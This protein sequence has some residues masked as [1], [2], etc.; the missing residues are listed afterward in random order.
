MKRS[1]QLKIT[2]GEKIARMEEILAAAKDGEKTRSLKKEEKTEFDT[3]KR[4]VEELETEIETAEFV[5]ARASQNND[6]GAQHQRNG[7][8]PQ[9]KRKAAPYSVGKAIQEFAKRGEEGLTGVEKEMHDEL[10]R[11]ITSEGLLVPYMESKR[12]QNTTTNADS[13]DVKIDPNLSIIGKEPLWSQMG[14]TI[15]P[16]LQGTIKLGKKAPDEAE[17]VS[18]KSEITQTAN[19]ESF[20]TMSPERYG[21]TDIFTKELLAQRNPA[22]HA[23]IVADMVKGCDRKLTADVY[24]IALAAATEVSTGALTVAG[25]NAL[26]A[27]IDLDG[28]FAMDRT[29]FFEAKGVKVDTGSG[30][31]LVGMTGANGVGQTY[32]GARVY[33]STLFADGDAKQYAIYG[34][35]EEVY[36]GFWG[37]LEILLN[38][39]TYQKKGQIEM[40]VNRLADVVCRNSGAFVRTP[41]LDETT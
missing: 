40:T 34:A 27:A 3:L 39:Y 4:E 41:D 13:I 24:T 35:W 2:K 17:V 20:V 32:D 1:E 12:D 9:I 6:N 19:T 7:D 36:M 11:G 38:P 30:R 26:M 22:V 37:A 25:F 16:G 5:E 23:A 8:G 14:L 28:A 31:F 21:I 10:S 18:E 15:L 33:Y 29:S